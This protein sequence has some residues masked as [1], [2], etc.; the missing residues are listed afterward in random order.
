M[1]YDPLLSNSLNQD[2][3]VDGS[4]IYLAYGT[5]KH[6]I[7]TKTNTIKELRSNMTVITG[8]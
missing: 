2:I 6:L 3:Y 7:G 4:N 1:K 5:N 8:A